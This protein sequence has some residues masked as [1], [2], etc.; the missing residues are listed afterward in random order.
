MNLNKNILNIQAQI[1]NTLEL[2]THLKLAVYYNPISVIH[3]KVSNNT[4]L[5]WNNHISGRESSSN[6]FLTIKQY[7]HL[8]NSGAYHVLL[9]DYSIIRLKFDTT[10]Y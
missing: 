6:A 4:M 9:Y 2:L 8:L 5:T 7:M 10:L 1:N 3:D